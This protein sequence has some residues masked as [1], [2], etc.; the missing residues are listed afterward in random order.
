MCLE[1][2]GQSCPLDLV[3][4]QRCCL[5]KDECIKSFPLPARRPRAH[6]VFEQLGQFEKRVKH[7]DSTGGIRAPT[8]HTRTNTK[9]TLQE[10]IRRKRY[11][12]L[13]SFTPFITVCSKWRVSGWHRYYAA[14]MPLPLPFALYPSRR[15]RPCGCTFHHLAGNPFGRVYHIV[16]YPNV[17]YAV[18][19]YTHFPKI[20]GTNV[21]WVGVEAC[22]TDEGDFFGM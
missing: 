21:F 18:C 15:L 10:E 9:R 2:L 16:L 22:N 20:E 3:G 7:L 17:M 8:K 19:L 13:I 1:N 6:P 5:P 14:K 12:N 11:K 4:L